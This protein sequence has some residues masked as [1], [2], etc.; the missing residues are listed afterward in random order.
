MYINCVELSISRVQKKKNKVD[1]VVLITSYFSIMTPM[2]K[3]IGNFDQS[4]N[5]VVWVK[6]VKLRELKKMGDLFL[7]IL[8]FLKGSAFALYE[9]L[10][11]SKKTSAADIEKT[12]LDAF[13]M[14]SF[15]AFKSFGDQ[16]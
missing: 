11:N 7:I 12:L 2:A 5:V 16:R 10:S 9:Q 1:I 14:D 3:M 4:G 15:K 8:S 13:A 6:K